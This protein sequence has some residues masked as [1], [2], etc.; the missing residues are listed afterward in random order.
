[1]PNS[2]EGHNRLAGWVDETYIKVEKE[3]MYLYRAVDSEGKTLDFCALVQAEM[4]KP[5]SASL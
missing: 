2:F 3:W 1:M 4:E 5:P